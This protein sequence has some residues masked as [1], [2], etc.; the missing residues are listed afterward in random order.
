LC[1]GELANL[2]KPNTVKVVTQD[3]EL[4]VTI[5]L[6]LTINL[7]SDNLKIAVAPTHVV[8]DAFVSK[9]TEATNDNPKWEIPDFNPTPKIEFGKKV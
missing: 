1:G 8:S 6:E 5:S 2:L 4:H 7:N 3:G 9:K